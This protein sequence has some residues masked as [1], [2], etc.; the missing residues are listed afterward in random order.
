MDQLQEIEKSGQDSAC[1]EAWYFV[2]NVDGGFPWP[3]FCHRRSVF[4]ES[5]AKVHEAMGKRGENMTLVR[6]DKQWTID[7]KSWGVFI[8]LPKDGF[9]KTHVQH[10]SG[11]IVS[12]E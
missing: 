11:A 7:W 8:F 4:V 5:F 12:L 6:V 10:A 9:P 2:H 3:V 1:K